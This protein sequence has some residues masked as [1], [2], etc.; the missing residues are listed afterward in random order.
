MNPLCGNFQLS[1]SRNTDFIPERNNELHGGRITV[2]KLILVP[3]G[4]TSVVDHNGSLFPVIVPRM[5][6]ILAKWGACSIGTENRNK[7]LPLSARCS[8]LGFV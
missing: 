6:A 4:F 7:D 5:H 2:G 3:H 1:I 8:F